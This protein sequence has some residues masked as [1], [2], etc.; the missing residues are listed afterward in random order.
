MHAGPKVDALKIVFKATKQ[1]RSF[2]KSRNHSGL[3]C[4]TRLGEQKA[5]QEGARKTNSTFIFQKAFLASVA[6]E[7]FLFTLRTLPGSNW[8]ELFQSET[9][10]FRTSNTDVRPLQSI[11]NGHCHGHYPLDSVQTD[12]ECMERLQ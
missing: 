12:L 10:S 3:K 8:N 5:E 2:R 9:F 4:Y 6:Q 1:Q 11:L 7:G